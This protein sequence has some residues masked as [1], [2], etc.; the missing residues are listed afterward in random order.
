[1]LLV[2]SDP[3][4]SLVNLLL[5]LSLFFLSKIATF[6]VITLFHKLFDLST[7]F[8]SLLNSSSLLSLKLLLQLPVFSKDIRVRFV[9]RWLW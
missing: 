7:H 8:I 2:L 6:I 4:S 3:I 9:D 5:F 1:M